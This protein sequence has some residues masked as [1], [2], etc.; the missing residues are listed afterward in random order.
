MYLRNRIPIFSRYLHR[1]C[2]QKK[3]QATSWLLNKQFTNVTASSPFTYNTCF[4]HVCFQLCSQK[5]PGYCLEQ[6]TCSFLWFSL[7]FCVLHIF[8]VF[9]IHVQHNLSLL[10]HHKIRGRCIK[11]AGWVR[12]LRR[13]L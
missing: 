9:V 11:N 6:I 3:Q 1:S 12:C 13:K 8:T 2:I 5:Y 4:Q 10:L 7:A